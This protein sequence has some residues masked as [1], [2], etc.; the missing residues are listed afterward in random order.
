[1]LKGPIALATIRT[2]A[3]L[4]LR[5]LVQAG[6]LLLVARML[7]PEQ[8][9]G[10]VGVAA[11][12]VMLG[13]LSTFGTHLV[14]LGAMS[15]D[16]GNR[17]KVLPYALP[18]TLLCGG[19]LLAFF[20]L[21]GTQVL[22][23]SGVVWDVLLAIGVAEMLLMP[24]SMLV[25]V[26]LM[27]LER[28][29]SSQLLQT[30]SLALRL[31]VAVLV[32]WWAPVEVLALY[33]YGYC[34]A[35]AVALVVLVACMPGC[36]PPPHLWRR[37]A[38][39]EL[40]EAA[41]YA[42]LNITA[43]GPAELDKTLAVRL[44]PL[45][46]AGLYAAGARVVGAVTLPV[47]SLMLSALPRLFREGQS[48]RAARLLRWIF[49]AT[50]LYGLG[51]ALALWWCAPLFTW[52]LGDQYEGVD[53]VIRW[54][55]FAVPGMALRIAAGS[56]LMALGKPWVR[57]GFEMVGLVVLSGAAIL[58]TMY[59]GMYG[60]ALALACSEWA[61]ALLGGWLLVRVCYG[62][63]GSKA[64]ATPAQYVRGGGD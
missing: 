29:A 59:W 49:G 62:S 24:L 50:A 14:L 64:A 57:A 44:L 11:L 43:M 33:S 48:Q 4:G 22:D 1:M 38:R 9:G 39:Q 47:V 10:F 51:L 61:M 27:A 54:L 31:I 36:W 7:G 8:F 35:A 60:M 41:S 42:V 52:L 3:V 23:G 46:A 37:P 32:G 53:E 28:T 16:P 34:M 21:I 55:C 18:T 12:A 5:L 56:A 20:M 26:E 2:S 45:P 25:V 19:V 40:R 6:T 15:K 17:E 30:L 13:T 63:R 58:M